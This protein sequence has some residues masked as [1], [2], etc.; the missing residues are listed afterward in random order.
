MGHFFAVGEPRCIIARL[1]AKRR[2]DQTE[3]GDGAPRSSY[4][5]AFSFVAPELTVNPIYPCTQNIDCLN[6]R[7]GLSVDP[8]GDLEAAECVLLHG[9]LNRFR[10]SSYSATFR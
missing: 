5:V 2:L 10:C 4:S 1:E 9:S 6:K 3:V 7:V 8:Q